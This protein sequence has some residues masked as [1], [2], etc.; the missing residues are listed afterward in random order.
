[1]PGGAYSS[2]GPLEVVLAV[3]SRKKPKRRKPVSDAVSEA[4]VM[5]QP[6]Q[7]PGAP[8]VKCTTHCPPCTA[9]PTLAVIS[10]SRCQ[11]LHRLR[12][13]Q[14]PVISMLITAEGDSTNSPTLHHHRNRRLTTDATFFPCPGLDAPPSCGHDASPPPWQPGSRPQHQHRRLTSTTPC[15]V[16][17]H[18][19]GTVCLGVRATPCPMPRSSRSAPYFGFIAVTTSQ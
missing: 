2:F 4:A 14:H 13:R 5:L 8:L 18:F 10:I 7:R 11:R 9:D 17:L 3:G 16:R 6:A 1:M 12:H 19:Q 15:I